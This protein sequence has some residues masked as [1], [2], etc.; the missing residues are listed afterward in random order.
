MSGMV[1]AITAAAAKA[2]KTL[3]ENGVQSAETLAKN[4]D[5]SQNPDPKKVMPQET[6]DKATTALQKETKQQPNENEQSKGFGLIDLLLFIPRLIFGFPSESDKKGNTKE[7]SSSPQHSQ[8]QQQENNGAK[9]VS[10]KD[11]SNLPSPPHISSQVL[12]AP[13]TAAKV[14]G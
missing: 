14:L 3:A 6:P 9:E 11:L 4:G 7:T 2:G 10:M 13:N 1:S 5:P 8:P 12:Q